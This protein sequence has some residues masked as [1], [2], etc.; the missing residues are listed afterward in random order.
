MKLSFKKADLLLILTCLFLFANCTE[1]ST[2]PEIID[3]PSPTTPPAFSGDLSTFFIGHSAINTI[4]DDYVKNL[5]EAADESTTL[6]VDMV[7][8][9]GGLSLESKMD[10]PEI[11][12]LFDSDAAASYDFIMV[13]EQWD[14]QWYHPAE[15]SLDTNDPVYGCPPSDYA[16]PADWVSPPDDWFPTP[17][18]L[19]QY[20]DAIAC[21]S[22]NETFL[23][24][25]QTWSLGYNEVENGATRISDPNYVPPTVDEMRAIQANGNALPDLP[26]ANRIAFEGVKWESWLKAANRPNI[27]QIPA[28]YAMSRLM[29]A[30]EAGEVPGFEAAANTQGLNA[31]GEVVWTDYLFYNDQYHLSTVGHYFVS[32]VIYA[33]IFNQN[34]QGLEIGSGD[35]LVSE[36][37]FEEQYPLEGITNAEYSV[38]LNAAGAVGVYDLRGFNGLDYMHDDL[39]D[40]LQNLAWTVVQEESEY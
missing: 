25:Y 4:V 34:P 8:A 38:L 18:P 39:R 20:A 19:Q 16:A 28:A 13:T 36:A 21:G 27:V 32:L 14:Y 3:H 15:Y 5:A 22:S 35:Y 26:L 11:A 31:S 37:F 23:F 30:M 2:S 12:P 1:E 24:Y 33:S 10:L 17:Y 40:Y 7:T 6:T 9:S 29:L